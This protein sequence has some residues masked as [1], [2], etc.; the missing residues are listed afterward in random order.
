MKTKFEKLDNGEIKLIVSIDSETFTK[1]HDL[2]FKKVQEFVE[3]DGFRKGNAPENLIIEKYGEMIILEEM[4]HLA[5]NETYYNSL[6]KENENKKDDDKILP[7]SNPKISIT[8]IGKGS[9]FEY[10]AVFPILPKVDLADYKKI[11]KEE[12]ES[13]TKNELDELKKKNDKAT[14][15]N[16]T[17]VSD[18]ELLEVLE[19]LRKARNVGGHVHEDGTV[20]TESHEHVEENGNKVDDSLPELNDEFA[21]SFGENFKTLEDLKVKI[22]ENLTLEKNSKLLDKKRNHILERLVAETSIKLPEILIE[23]ELERMKA[24]MKADMERYGSK[25]EEYL[26]H[27]KKTEEEIKKDWRETA[28][29]RTKSQLIL[30]E[31]AKKEKIEV[32]KEEVF[33]EALKIMNQMPEANEDHVKSYVTQIL[34]NEKVMKFLDG[35]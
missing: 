12:S 33:A 29:K 21:Q 35:E 14:L 25:W 24:T 16:L 32:S 20:H 34:L 23:D 5:I 3:I 18:E 26:E 6:V 22:K 31:I 9:D 11:S 2:G 27:V 17:T 1:Y 30:N 28:E 4:A 15:E 13:V 7:I 8:K 19:N 10:E